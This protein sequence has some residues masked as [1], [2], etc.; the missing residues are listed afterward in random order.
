MAT[1]RDVTTGETIADQLEYARSVVSR[2][3][4]LM[5][6]GELRPGTGLLI[7]PCGS[8]HMMFMRFPIDA[9]FYD[10]EQRVTKV[11]R[12]VRRWTGMAFGGKGAKGV[13]ELPVGAAANIEAGHQLEFDPPI[14]K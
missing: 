6:R 14:T 7:H 2:T 13:V 3:R 9:V 12:G 10:K 11:A 5:M 8:I 4:G 1:L